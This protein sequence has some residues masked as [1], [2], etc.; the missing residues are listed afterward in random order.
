M[1]TLQ[2]SLFAAV[3]LTA[4]FIGG[5]VVSGRMSLTQPSTAA[6][7]PAAGEQAQAPSS[8]RAASIAAASAMPDLSSIADLAAAS[9]TEAPSVPVHIIG[10][11]G[12]WNF[13]MV[14]QAGGT[15][16]AVVI[17]N[18][19]DYTTLA[20]ALVAIATSPFGE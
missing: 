4:G 5:L 12:S 17:E 15:N 14:A 18:E 3:V 10:I 13:D 19:A 6:P 2:K 20:D 16:Q 1:T 8:S 11:D 7:G 9:Y